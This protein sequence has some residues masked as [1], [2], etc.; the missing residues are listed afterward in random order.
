MGHSSAKLL[1]RSALHSDQSFWLLAALTYSRFGD[2]QL[3]LVAALVL[4]LFSSVST[5][6]GGYDVLSSLYSLSSHHLVV[7]THPHSCASIFFCTWSTLVLPRLARYGA[8]TRGVYQHLTLNGIKTKTNNK[9]IVFYR[10][11]S[12]PFAL[13]PRCRHRRCCPFVDNA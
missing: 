4:D 10:P 7:V 13:L 12:M 1:W 5:L 2:W 11:P 6:L 9:I 3:R 8:L